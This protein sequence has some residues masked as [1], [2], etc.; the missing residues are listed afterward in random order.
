MSEQATQ[1]KVINGVDV[2]QLFENIE[3]LKQSPH[4]G[5][6]EAQLDNQWINGGHNRSTI[7]NFYGVGEHRSHREAFVL[8]AD[9][10]PVLLGT[11]KGPN[12]VEY[13]LKALAACVT[14]SLVYHAAAR[15]IQLEEVQAHVEGDIDLRGFLGIDETVPKGYKNIRIK[16]KIKAD[17][18]D[19]QLEE[20]CQLGPTFSPVFNTLTNGVSVDVELDR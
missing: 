3:A 13:L 9:E 1:Q 19:E 16:Y 2:T 7:Q 11:D 6:F 15:G 18:P 20:I 14:T 4:L 12:P 17:V 8:D 5:D 10:P